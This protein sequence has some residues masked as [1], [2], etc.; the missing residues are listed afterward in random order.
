MLAVIAY[1]NIDAGT[2]GL[3]LTYALSITQ[4]LN[5]MVRN[6]CDIEANIV[7][8]ERIK[9]VRYRMRVYGEVYW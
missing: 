2:V 4:T 5:W 3:S 1:P 6:A 8:V 7:S 9:E